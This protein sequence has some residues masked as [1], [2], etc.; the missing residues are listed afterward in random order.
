[1]EGRLQVY[2]LTTLH[3][4]PGGFIFIVYIWDDLLTHFILSVYMQ[5]LFPTASRLISPLKSNPKR[6]STTAGGEP[7]E[8]DVISQ[9]AQRLRR[10]TNS[11]KVVCPGFRQRMSNRRY[12]RCALA[13][14][15]TTLV[16]LKRF[17]QKIWKAGCV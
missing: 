11:L 1:M 2:I 5:V 15:M 6:C 8:R 16:Y 4:V 3:Y 12:V 17:Y 14:R 7:L 9:S 13:V 10:N